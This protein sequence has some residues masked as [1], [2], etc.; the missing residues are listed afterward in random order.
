MR[1]RRA[2]SLTIFLRLA[3]LALS[4][5]THADEA[6]AFFDDSTVSEISIRAR[7]GAP[8]RSK[9]GEPWSRPYSTI[10]DRALR[11]ATSRILSRCARRFSAAAETLAMSSSM[12]HGFIR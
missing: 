1:A 3:V 8:S 5:A 10:P 11:T 12:S 4:A 9:N 7:P 2:P 6:D